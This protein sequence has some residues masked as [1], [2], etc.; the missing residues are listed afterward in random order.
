[1]LFPLSSLFLEKDLKQ[2]TTR[3][4]KTDKYLFFKVQKSGIS[5]EMFPLLMVIVYYKL[6][7]KAKF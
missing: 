6:K 5:S 7:N 3:T 1:M 4:Q 2:G